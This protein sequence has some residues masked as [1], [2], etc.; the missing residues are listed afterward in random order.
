MFP[1]K[2]CQISWIHPFSHHFRLKGRNLIRTALHMSLL[3][4]D[5]T[6]SAKVLWEPCEIWWL[7]NLNLNTS[8][9]SPLNLNPSLNLQLGSDPD[10]SNGCTAS[11][12]INTYCYLKHDLAIPWYEIHQPKSL[13][14]KAFQA[15]KS[16][17]FEP[18]VYTVYGMLIYASHIRM[19]LTIISY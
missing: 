1:V 19:L 2:L 9:N 3:I 11:P 17:G 15:Q 5:G 12:I 7:S 10:P 18:I 4:Q 13:T 16:C 14:Q 6:I 8:L